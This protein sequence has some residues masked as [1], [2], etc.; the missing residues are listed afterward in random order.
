[1]KKLAYKFPIH[2]AKKTNI[3][4]GV[5]VFKMKNET[6]LGWHFL[7]LGYY[8]YCRSGKASNFL[9]NLPFCKKDTSHL[10]QTKQLKYN[11]FLLQFITSLPL[12]CIEV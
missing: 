6:L 5:I 9:R 2:K 12:T 3:L 7:C 11:F 4:K 1:M 10:V 8:I